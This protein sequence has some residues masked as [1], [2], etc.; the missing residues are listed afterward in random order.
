MRHAV[1]FACLAYG[2][3]LVFHQCDERGDDD[4][5][6]LHQEC[7]QL[8]AEAFAATGRHEDE[9][10]VAGQDFLDDIFLA[11]LERVEPEVA[12]QRP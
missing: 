9:H 3:N 4:G 5:R 10:V 8:V 12:L 7:G 11:V 6:P 1:L 2:I